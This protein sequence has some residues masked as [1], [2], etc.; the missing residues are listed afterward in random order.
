M[1]LGAWRNRSNEPLGLTWV[2][3]MKIL[4]VVFGTIPVQQENWQPKL[5]K[6]EKSLNLWKSRS[7]SFIGKSLIVNVLG[8]RKFIYLVK[9]LIMPKWVLSRINQSIWP[10]IWGSRMEMVSLNTCFLGQASGGINLCNLKIKAE[11]LKLAS[12]VVTID[13]PEDSSFF[14]AKYFVGRRLS[15]LRKQWSGLRDNSAPSA[16]SMTPFYDRCL[17]TLAEMDEK[18]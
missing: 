3:K 4:G 16:A 12:L 7:L 14:L 10:F 13:S 15:T 1:W 11:T 2:R 9:T 17:H 8:L 5:N 6:L 18:N